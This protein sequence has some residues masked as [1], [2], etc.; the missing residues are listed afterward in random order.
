VSEGG[1][2]TARRTASKL[3]GYTNRDSMRATRCVA[4]GATDAAQSKTENVAKTCDGRR[5]LR[6][7]ARLS[8]RAWR[9]AS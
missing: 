6:G 7:G 1:Q 9:S 3:A 2:T 8:C 5:P 4:C